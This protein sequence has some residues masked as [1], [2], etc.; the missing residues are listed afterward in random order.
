M[1]ERIMDAPVVVGVDTGGT[2]TDFVIRDADGRL[3]VRKLSSTP[4]DPSQSVL[5]GIREAQADSRLSEGYDV[6]HGTTVATNALL[7]RRGAATALITT[8]GF[9]DVLA[10]GRQARTELY[11]FAPGKPPVLLPRERCFELAER[12]DWRGQIVTPLD[13]AHTLTLLGELKAQGIES[14]AVC[15]LFSYLN[16]AHER[17]VGR[18]ARERGFAVSLS[19]DIAPEP[20]EYERAATTAANAFV[21]PLMEH[22]LTNLQTQTALLR[23]AHLRVMQSNGGALSAPEAARRPITTA[24]SGPAGGIVAAAYVGKR[25]GFA[26]LLTFDM[27]GTSTDV[28]LIAGGQCQVVTNGSLGGLPLRTPQLDIHTVGA[29]GGSLARLDS[30]GGLRVGPQSA[31]ADPGPVAYGRG[32]TL[33]VTDANVFMGRLPAD[34]RLGGR[35]PLDAERVRARFVEFA[36]SLNRTPEQAALGV[37]TVVNVAMTRALRHVSVERGHDPARFTLLS[38]GGAGGLHACALADALQMPTVLIPRFPGAFSAL[39]LTL[40]QTRRE[41][42]HPL[43][44]TRLPDMAADAAGQEKPASSS[45]RADKFS[46]D[47]GDANRADTGR[48]LSALSLSFNAFLNE[49]R[50]QAGVDM[51]AEGIR[52]GQWQEEMLLDM[53]YVGQSFELRV[54][55]QHTSAQGNAAPQNICARGSI[56]QDEA[57]SPNDAA[58]FSAAI[59]PTLLELA[60]HAFH[61]L[62]TQ[63]FGY[64]NIQEPVE[65]TGLRLLATGGVSAQG[66]A[67]APVFDPTTLTA[68][69][70]EAPATP[71]VPAQCDTVRRVYIENDWRDVPMYSRL[72]LRPGQ[73]F[74]GP[75]LVAQEDATTYIAPNWRAKVDS[76][77]NLVLRR[78]TIEPART[79]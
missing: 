30:A 15:F 66:S 72:T 55:I 48:F 70:D 12:L 39:G 68:L 79:S 1:Q 38:F 34:V 63:R 41:Y 76:E 49:L 20:R 42:A 52:A 57:A 18:L 73:T 32:E 37:L 24:L 67:A 45:L 31:G 28:A 35:V 4:Y 69:S 36:Q 13:E 40:A 61:T 71:D 14:L 33:T 27:G 11:A 54:P 22:Y 6:V 78:S 7:Q 47:T 77:A 51:A 21:A 43:P 53:R 8:A 74:D 75:A 5:A 16:P 59:T 46:L 23:A 44:P 17:M 50:G 9:R 58:P 26:N 64:A 56:V 29:G 60:V 65:V 19:S 10:I 25:A 3:T 62:H 2:F